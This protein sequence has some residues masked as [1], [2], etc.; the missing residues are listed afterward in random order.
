MAKKLNFTAY[1]LMISNVLNTIIGLFGSTFLVAY[2]LQ[3]SSENIPSIALHYIITYAVMLITF[4]LLVGLVKRTKRVGVFRAGIFAKCAFILVI[5]LL[6]EDITTY[7]IPISLLNGV[8]ESLYWSSYNILKNEV[9]SSKILMKF[10]NM[11]SIVNKIVNLVLPIVLGTAI[12]F[13]SFLYISFYVLALA[14]AQFIFSFFIKNPD[15]TIEKYQFKKFLKITKQ[16]DMKPLK[17]CFWMNFING[18]KAIIGTLTTIVIMMTFGSNMSLGF[19]SSI[20]SVVSIIGTFIFFKTYKANK[21]KWVY[22]L[23]GIL[24]VFAVLGLLFNMGKVTFIIFN[25]VYT[26]CMVTPEFM[27]DVIKNRTIREVSMHRYIAEHQAVCEIYTNTARILIYGILY[28]FA[29]F[30]NTLMFQIFLVLAMLSVPALC[31][32]IHTIEINMFNFHKKRY[33]EKELKEKQKQ[34]ELEKSQKQ[35]QQQKD[36][37]IVNSKNNE[38]ENDDESNG[39]E[40]TT[41]TKESNSDVVVE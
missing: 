11:N 32:I 31:M 19:I 37:E 10:Q 29:I 4:P 34:A 39:V 5:S 40:E 15:A 24:P 14:I 8:A 23:S 16:P 12:E 26:V 21:S 6:K 22:L 17:Q 25:F 28:L 13:S 27:V 20:F 18:L 38:I 41:S 33:E 3:V 2:F 36:E 7:I 1:S 30:H 35:E 9:L